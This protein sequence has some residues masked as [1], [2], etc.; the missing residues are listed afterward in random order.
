M[1]WCTDCG[2]I[3]TFINSR[4][5]W[6][7]VVM[8]MVVIVQHGSTIS[9]IVPSLNS[10][11]IIAWCV[12]RTRSSR[13]IEC[14]IS[15]RYRNKC[16]L[17]VW[18]W[19]RDLHIGERWWPPNASTTSRRRSAS[20]FYTPQLASVQNKDENVVEGG[21][22]TAK[23]HYNSQNLHCGGVWFQEWEKW[24]TLRSD[25]VENE[26]QSEE[27]D[28]ENCK[29]SWGPFQNWNTLLWVKEI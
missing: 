15:R 13:R 18:N 17:M 19:V 12:W 23:I 2:C 27:K 16:R 22:K 3:Q 10:W 29:P 6:T 20:T 4:R 28:L 1:C 9:P 26:D 21:D 7:L 14:R 11:W 5:L 8:V 25:Y 24:P